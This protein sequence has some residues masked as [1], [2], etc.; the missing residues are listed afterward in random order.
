MVVIS[1]QLTIYLG[2]RDFIDN[3]GDVE[4]VGKSTGICAALPALSTLIIL[5]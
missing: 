4:P 3:V 1:L 5:C 2:K